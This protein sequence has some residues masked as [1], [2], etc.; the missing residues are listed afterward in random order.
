[1]CTNYKAPN[2]D[3]GINELKIGIG[4]L[5]RRAPWD[6]DVWPD[7]RAPVVLPD[8]DGSAVTEAV[9]GFWPKFM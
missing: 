9:F 1:M 7:Y 4:D 2:E 8:G 3:P 6:V 5:F